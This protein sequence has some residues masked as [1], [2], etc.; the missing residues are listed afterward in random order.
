MLDITL[1]SQLLIFLCS[2]AM[3]SLL[4]VFYSFLRAVRTICHNK[5]A[6]TVITD[7]V[8]MF[9]SGVTVYLFSTGYT[10]GI[11]RYYVVCGS[12]LGF[13]A[14]K[15]TLGKI[16]HLIFAGLY[17]FF[18]K[19]IKTVNKKVGVIAKKLLKESTNMLYNIG[20]K[21]KINTIS[22]EGKLQNGTEAP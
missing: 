20:N 4:S 2:V 22:R 14:F 15:L 21:K 12:V 7:L 6:V 8:F 17:N 13:F 3:G 5:K 1:N 11:V 16:F 18:G 10:L 19:I 9:V